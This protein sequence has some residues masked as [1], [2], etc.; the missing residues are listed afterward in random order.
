MTS[1]LRGEFVN[2]GATEH[3][4]NAARGIDALVNRIGLPGLKRA[5]RLTEGRFAGFVRLALKRECSDNPAGGPRHSLG[6][7]SKLQNHIFAAP[8][9]RIG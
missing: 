1:A 5:I 8:I 3:A 7:S 2:Y 6:S 9:G 4:L